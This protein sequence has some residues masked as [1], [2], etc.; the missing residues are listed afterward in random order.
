MMARR[1]LVAAGLL[2]FIAARLTALPEP[3]GIDEGI[4][5]TA[6]WG[7]TRGL[8]LYR[9][10]WDQ[11]P[12]GIHLLYAGAIAI[13]GTHAWIAVVL[14]AAAWTA[15]VISVA[16]IAARLASARAAWAASIVLAI[17]TFPSF[18]Y[19]YGGFLE[20]AVPETFIAPLAAA[21]VWMILTGRPA[22]AGLAIGAAAVFK[23]T[24]LVYWPA[25]VLMAGLLGADAKRVAARM[26]LTL[27]LPWLAV[28]I[29]LWSAGAVA[30]ARIAIVDYNGGYVAAGSGLVALPLRF[31]HEI[32]RLVK[33]DPAWLLA[34]VGTAA[35][36]VAWARRDSRQAPPLLPAL[37]FV[38]LAAVLLAVAANG[39]R[40][41]PTYFLPAFAPLALT[42]GWFL[43]A[44]TSGRGAIVVA[45][46]V[47]LAVA[48]T[49]RSHSVEHAARFVAADVA[50]MRGTLGPEPY[51]DLFGGRDG[52]GYSAR[53]NEEIAAYL[54]AH[55]APGD[56]LYIFGMAPA[57][58][59]TSNRLPANRF[60][61]TFPAVA[62]FMHRP[63]FGDDALAEDLTRAAPAWL[64]LEANNRD[65]LSGWRV[66]DVYAA[67]SIRRLLDGY[68]RAIVIKDF[69]V[70]RRTVQ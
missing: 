5:A 42:G 22:L 65:S 70:L 54:R 51:L 32:W 2:L 6:G 40:M 61:W 17:A 7:L 37:A 38:W 36:G 35:A 9:D 49:W 68:Q 31:A 58:Y 55:A 19:P 1:A 18:A 11:K 8:M 47:V 52:R 27:A 29:W 14:D 16:A 56:R 44:H 43:D 28:A 34:L 15:V 41:Y 13:L 53:A 57:V 33:S 30:D 67:P 3:L 50:R 4:F 10:V 64:V 66:E 48:V 59:F 45:V 46:A 12:P 39:I 21:A 69:T 20:R 60:V 62:G 25:C 23:P 24:A 26:A 63:G